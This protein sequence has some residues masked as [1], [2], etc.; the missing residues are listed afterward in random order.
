[1]ENS[2]GNSK[3]NSVDITIP[4]EKMYSREEVDFECN[5]LLNKLLIQ[6][7]NKDLINYPDSNKIAKWIIKN[8]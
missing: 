5:R 8:L 2:N 7:R 4:E 6:E 1:M 3:I